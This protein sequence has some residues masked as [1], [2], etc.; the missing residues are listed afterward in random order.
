MKIKNNLECVHCELCDWSYDNE[1]QKYPTDYEFAFNFYGQEIRATITTKE[2]QNDNP[3]VNF[4]YCETQSD[5]LLS[6]EDLFQN[7][8]YKDNIRKLCKSAWEELS[9]NLSYD[10]KGEKR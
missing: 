10:Y 6:F 5:L 1:D 8:N 9:D 7:G 4:A 3:G 2:L